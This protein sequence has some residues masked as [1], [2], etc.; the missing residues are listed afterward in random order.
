MTPSGAADEVVCDGA[1]EEADACEVA[2]ASG[3]NASRGEAANMTM[4]TAMA[5][6]AKRCRTNLKLVVPIDVMSMMIESRAIVTTRPTELEGMDEPDA[7]QAD[8]DASFKFIRRVNRLAGGFWAFKRAIHVALQAR[9]H[10]TEPL[11]ILDVGTGCAD[12]PIA[13]VAWALRHNI[14]IRVTAIDPHAGSIAAAHEC[15]S[16][17]G[18]NANFIQLEQCGLDD[19]AQHWRKRKWDVVHAAMMLHH[20]PDDMVPAALASMARAS[21]GLV[22][23]NDLWR[24]PMSAAIVHALTLFSSEF[25]RHDARLSVAKGFSKCEILRHVSRAGLRTDTLSMNPFTARFLLIATPV[26]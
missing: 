3:V 26:E 23:W 5:T 21:C 7:S 20:F 10:S 16:Q 6:G 22:V 11:E 18:P 4:H 19:V 8:M 1:C 13:I 14:P 25:V 12:L 17:F 9:G 2:A 24:T 15:L